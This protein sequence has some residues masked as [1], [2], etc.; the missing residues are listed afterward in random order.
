MYLN[1][2]LMFLSYMKAFAKV[3]ERVL[4]ADSVV[5]MVRT[6]GSGFWGR[7]CRS[8]RGAAGVARTVLEVSSA[9]K[10]VVRCMAKFWSFA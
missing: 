3:S 7:C 1:A 5:F 2:S 8:E 6:H 9:R 4:V 10:V